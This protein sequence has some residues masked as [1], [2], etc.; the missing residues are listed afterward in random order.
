MNPF[1]SAVNNDKTVKEIYNV[2]RQRATD[3][4][5]QGVKVFIR[6]YE[7]TT[8]DAK[9]RTDSYVFVAEYDAI[10]QY[11]ARN[12]VVTNRNDKVYFVIVKEY[13]IIIPI[14][15]KIIIIIIIIRRILTILS[16]GCSLLLSVL[17]VNTGDKVERTFDIQATKI[18]HF[19]QSRLS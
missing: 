16:L 8:I 9:R 11:Q 15:I 7:K 14:I 19:R 5:H 3:C 4:A 18:T 6:R 17:P 13:S 2:Q 12:H 10:C 1:I